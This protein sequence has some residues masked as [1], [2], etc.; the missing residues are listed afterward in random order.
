MG[1]YPPPGG[2]G[3]VYLRVTSSTNQRKVIANLGKGI[4][5]IGRIA[6]APID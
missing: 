6:G 5:P 3:E 1:P 2:G 4:R